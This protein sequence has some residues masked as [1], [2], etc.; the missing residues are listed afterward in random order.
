MVLSATTY[1]AGGMLV[2]GATF[3]LKA[4]LGM[5]HV[6]NVVLPTSTTAYLY[7]YNSTTGGVQ[8][9][10]SNTASPFVEVSG[11]L[12][13]TVTFLIMSVSD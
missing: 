2:S 8:I 9:F 11:S 5:W 4:V 6:A 3:G 10:Q 7:Q 12:T 13:A 1:V